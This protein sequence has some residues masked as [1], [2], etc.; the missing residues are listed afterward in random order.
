MQNKTDFCEGNNQKMR[1]I[2]FV[3]EPRDTALLSDTITLLM[4]VLS[5][6]HLVTPLSWFCF[7]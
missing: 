6:I 5:A 7:S 4:A 1:S 2:P 3:P